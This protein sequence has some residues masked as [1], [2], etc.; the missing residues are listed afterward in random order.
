VQ[1]SAAAR[2]WSEMLPE[3]P[4]SR[5]SWRRRVAPTRRWLRHR[6]PSSVKEGNQNVQP[7]GSGNLPLPGIFGERLTGPRG[8]AVLFATSGQRQDPLISP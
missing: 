6:P 7:P 4:H 8:D 3:N 5:A 2:G 1:R